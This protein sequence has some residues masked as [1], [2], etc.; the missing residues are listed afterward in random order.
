MY[1]KEEKLDVME[2]AD[3]FPIEVDFVLPIF[4]KTE[5]NDDDKV[6]MMKMNK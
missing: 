6:D 3:T 4:R 2:H 5:N 1:R